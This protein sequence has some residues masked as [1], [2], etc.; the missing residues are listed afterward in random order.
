MMVETTAHPARCS[1]AR[2]PAKA[3]PCAAASFEFR[4]ELQR[5][6]AQASLA[7]LA[8]ATAVGLLL[9]AL[10]LWPAAGRWLAPLSYGRWMPVHLNLQLFGWCSLPVVGVLM[11]RMLP[12]GPRWH[13]AASVALA[14]WLGALLAGS[15]DWLG[16]RTSGKLFLDWSGA[17]RFA[18]AAAQCLLWLLLAAG[19]WARGRLKRSFAVSRLADLGLLLLLAGVPAALLFAEHADVYPP[20]NPDSGGATGHSLLASSLGLVAVGLLLP[21]LLGRQARRRLV[22]ETV[23][24]WAI[25]AA[26][27]AVY[28]YIGHGS[29]SNHE[30][31]QI[32]GL[33]TLLLWPGLLVWWFRLF[34]WE[35]SQRRWLRATGVW[36]AALVADGFVLFLPGV[37]D[38]LRFT[39]ALVAH[40]HLAMAGLLSAF[41]MLVL[42][43]LAPH[44]VLSRAL[45]DRRL[46]LAWN[47]G[48]LLMVVV[49]TWVGMHEPV[50]DGG[51]AVIGPGYGLRLAAGT[52]MVAAAF[53]WLLAASRSRRFGT[54]GKEWETPNAT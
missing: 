7:C 5:S 27:W 22:Q 54:P 48:G 46:F 41:N 51:G 31:E 52:V 18:L 8:V 42:I 30:A 37:L 23:T 26:N 13:S 19:W 29:V 25:L 32:A 14:V 40:S 11:L 6:V 2:R 24:I 53:A 34:A 38:R 44:S 15:L 35:P 50:M 45:D 10:L 33:G 43:S 28:A 4:A 3:G 12:P 21:V 49:L 16:G 17:D 36:C 39:N 9:A 20:V 47:G 1:G